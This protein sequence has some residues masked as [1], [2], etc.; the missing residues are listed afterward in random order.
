[1]YE[2][3]KLKLETLLILGFLSDKNHAAMTKTTSATIPADHI[4]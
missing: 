1:M 4:F 2:T 3:I